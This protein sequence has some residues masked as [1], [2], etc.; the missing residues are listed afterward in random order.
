V[1]EGNEGRK[2]GRDLAHNGDEEKEH[3]SMTLA[4]LA[5]RDSILDA[6]LRTYR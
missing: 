2:L 5:R 1:S 6:A 3:A 4:W